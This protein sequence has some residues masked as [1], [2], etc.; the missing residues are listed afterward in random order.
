MGEKGDFIVF[1]SPAIGE[2]EIQ[3]VVDSIR[4]GWLST[5]PKVARFEELF[6]RYVGSPH[7]I[8]LNSCTA[9]LHLLLLAAGV[10]P[11]D[12][13]LTTP[14]TFAATANVILHVG[15]RP[16]FADVDP[17]TMN[18]DPSEVRRVLEKRAGRVKAMVVVHLAGRPCDMEPLWELARE[19]K[20]IILEDAAHATEAW[21]KGKKVGTLGDGAAFSFYVTKNLVTG[22]GGMVTTHREDWAELIRMLSLHGMSRGAWKRYSSS[23]YSHYRILHAGYKYNMMDLQAAMGIHQLAR[24]DGYLR[25]REQIWQAYDDAFSDLPVRLPAPAQEGTIHA[26]HLYTPLLELESLK[27]DRDCVLEELR[28]LGIGTGVHFISLHLQ[29]LYERVLGCSERDF[30]NALDISRRTLSLPLSA[31]LTDGDVERV[32]KAFR[33]VLLKNAKD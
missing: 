20:V 26:R 10:G 3:E 13:V 21:Y 32:I 18:L 14:M 11:G 12:E 19:H 17:V 2:E 16:V 6:R 22:E 4:S 27:V 30:P 8:A 23:G 28:A 29:P 25:R 9:G 24:L 1:G 7:A 33:S 5:G 31:K 15:A